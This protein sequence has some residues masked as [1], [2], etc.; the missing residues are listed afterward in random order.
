MLDKL[1]TE[2]SVTLDAT[3]YDQKFKELIQKLFTKKKLSTEK[4]VVILID[5]Y[6]KPLIDY[7]DNLEKAKMHQQIL[8]TFY[9]ILK[10]SD[11]YIELLFITGVSKF[12]KVS[13]F[14]DLNNLEDITMGRQFSTLTGYTQ[15]E[16]ETY[17][18]PYIVELQEEYGGKTQLLKSLKSWY[19]GYSWD[20]KKYVYNPFSVLRF[21][22]SQE[23]SNFWFTTGTP[24]FLIKLLH[25]RMIY[26]L[27][28]I[29]VGDSAFESYNLDHLETISLLFQTGYLTIKQKDEI[30]IYTLDYP[31]KE[32][33]NSM[34]QHLIGAFSHGS[35]IES[36]PIVVKLQDAFIH[37]DPTKIISIINGVL[38]SIPSHIFIA[39]KEAYYHSVVHLVL[40][41][42]GQYIES[43]VNTSDGRMDAVI[44]TKKYIYILE[45]KLDKT[46]DDA[47]RQIEQKQ[48]A[49]RFINDGREI[50][51][52]GINFSSSTKSVDDWKVN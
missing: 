47:L 36:T 5:E 44:K 32:V 27:E 31:N 42:L 45:F 12:S 30:G 33:K 17:F 16:L 3:T 9:A 43:E 51:T 2:N 11:P 41:Y 15:E 1:A 46:A 21:F 20:G 49:S 48:Y 25:E 37:K 23:F 26:N 50:I 52:M 18:E 14:S 4:K 22:K 35:E 38:K 28:N 6:D 19:N 10:D 40:T 8:K 24:V 34:L 39:Q 7:M 29:Q 13:V